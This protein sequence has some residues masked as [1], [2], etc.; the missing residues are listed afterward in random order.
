MKA[1]MILWMFL[2]WITGRISACELIYFIVG[3]C[4]TELVKSCSYALVGLFVFPAASLGI[5]VIAIEPV[6]KMCNEFSNAI[7]RRG[8]RKQ[9]DEFSKR[10]QGVNTIVNKRPY[11]F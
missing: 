8:L 1:T 3:C 6:W 7:Q 11:I 9:K 2:Y 10:A 4:V 5:L